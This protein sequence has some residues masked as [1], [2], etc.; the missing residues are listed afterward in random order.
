MVVE[1]HVSPDALMSH[2]EFCLKPNCS[3]AFL[4]E[5]AVFTIHPAMPRHSPAYEDLLNSL[6]AL[7]VLGQLSYKFPTKDN[8]YE[9]RV[10]IY[11]LKKHREVHSELKDLLG[12]GR[13]CRVL[14]N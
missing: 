7:G 9:R 12:P 4:N 10:Y 1:K 3:E 13:C 2:L 6:D 5:L 8:A 14:S 11:A